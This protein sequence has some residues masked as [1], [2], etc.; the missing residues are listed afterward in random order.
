MLFGI[1]TGWSP[2]VKAEGTS[3]QSPTF[4]QDG[5]V[6]VY[7][8]TDQSQNQVYING[9]FV[10]WASFEPLTLEGTYNNNGI[11]Q[12]LFSYTLTTDQ[13]NQVGGVIQ[14]KFTPSADWNGAYTDP[15]NQSPKKDGNSTIYFLDI[16]SAT[17]QLELGQSIEVKAYRIL[18]DGSKQYMTDGINWQSDNDKVTVVNGVVTAATDATVNQNVA[19]SVTYLGVTAKKEFTI[20]DEVLKS[21]VMN[22]DGTVTFNAMYDGATLNLVGSMNG[23]NNQG[24]PMTKNE[25]GIFTVTTPLNPGTYEYKFFPVSGS[26]DN[27]FKDPLN[28]LEN[29]GNSVV[30]VP[31]IKIE[32]ADEIQLGDSITL[33]AKMVNQNGEITDINPIWSLKENREGITLQDGVLSVAAN[34]P[35]T[36]QDRIIVVAEKD[37]YHAEK[38]INILE[39]MYSYTIH[40][41][42]YDGKQNQWDMWIWLDG[43]EGNAYPF[44]D[45]INGF[46][47]A[48]YKFP[49]NKINVIVRP[50]NWSTQ[51]MTRTVEVK[52]GTSVEVWIIQ[53]VE[54][55]FYSK[56]EADIS[57][58]VKAALMDALDTIIVSTTH[59]VES[60]D[61]D[62]FV[63]SDITSN[64][65]IA[66]TATKL[67][68][69]K[70]KLTI[71]D[72]SQVDVR[73]LYQVK[74]NRFAPANVTVRKALDDPKFYYNGNDLGLTYSKE[75]S[76]FKVWAPTATKVSVAL[77]DNAGTYNEA[78]VVL[79]HTGSTEYLMN[80]AENGVW[81][82]TIDGDLVGKYYMYKVEL[83]DGT[84]NYAVDPYARAVSAN[85]QRTAI[86]DLESTIPN[87]WNPNDKPA[88]VNPTDAVIYELHVRDFSSN[89][90]SKMQYKGKF[91][92]FT[93]TGLKDDHGNSIGIDH[94][95]DLGITHVHLLPSYD[96]KTINELTVDDPTST[97]PKFNWGYDPQN[98]NVPEGS[99]STNPQNPTA[100]ITEFKEMVQALHDKGIRVIMDVV[101]NHTYSVEDGPFNKIVPGYFYRTNDDGKYT[102]GSGVGN[103]VASER[104]M[105]RKFIKDSVKYWAEE[106][107][108]DGF[109]FD[110]M[111]L[112]DV[113]T[114]TQLTK[115]LKEQVDPTILIYGE[116]WQ[117]GGSPLPAELQ[118]TKGQQKDKGFA[119]FNDNLRGAI[120]GGSDDASKGFATGQIGTEAGIVTGIKGAIDDFTNSPTE[121]INYVTAHD[122]LNLWDKIVKT[123]G[124]ED[125][126]GFLNIQDGVLIDGGSVEEAVANA[127]PYQYVGDDVLANETVKRSLLANGI[128][129]TSQGIPFIHAGDEI[130]RTKYG[131][132]NS[133][134]SPDAVNQIR[135]ENKDRFKPVFDY[136]QGLIALRKSH[137]A[138]R[139]S[140]KEAVA[141]NFEV[142]KS[143]GNIVVFKL[144]NHAN[145]DPWE[146][147]VVIYNANSSQA[148]IN[149]P[150]DSTQWNVVVND[151]QAG[152][153]VIDT[154]EGNQVTVPGLSMMVLYDE[155]NDYTPVISKIEVSP[156]VMGL[157]IG[158]TKTIQGIVKDQYNN[159][160]LNETISW[161]S[162]NE[163]VATVT[164]TGRVTA[165]GE[166]QAIITASVGDISAT[167][168][169]NVGTL[170]PTTIQLTGKNYVFEGQSTQLTADVKDQFQQPMSTA[171]VSWQSSD[172]SIATVD[173][174]GKVTG[175]KTGTVTIT[176]QAGDVTASKQIEVKAYVQRTIQL[177]YI[178]DDQDYTDWNLWVWGTGVQD[179][180][181]DIDQVV[182]GAALFTIE[183]GP[184]T[185][186]V[187]FIV[188]KGTDWNTAKQDIPDDRY[189][190][191]DIDESLTK[192]TVTSMVKEIYTVPAVK[193]PVLENGNLTFYYR[194]PDLFKQNAMDSIKSVQVKVN[195]QTYDMTYMPKEERFVYTLQAISEG[196]YDYSFLVT[197]D[198]NTVEV[199]DPYNTQDGKSIIEYKLP[200]IQLDLSLTPNQITYQENTVLKVHPI[201]EEEVGIKEIYVDLT[202]LGGPSKA[203]VDLT[204]LEQTLSVKDDIPAGTKTLQV[205]LVDEFGNQHVQSINLEI[206]PRQYVGNPL[207]FDWDEA[208]IY[209]ILT[210]RF[211]NGDPSNDDPNGE[212]YDKSHPETYHGGDLKGITDKLDYLQSL[213]INTIWISPI[214]DNID[215]NLRY[216]KE[217]PQYG[218]HG[219]WAKDFTQVDEHFGDLETL[220]ELIDKA[221]D[222]GIKIMVDVVLNHAGY[223][224]KASDTGEGI[225]NFPTD[226]DRAR[227]A[228]MFRD[229]GTDTIK[230]ELA[231]LPDFKT[232]D[233]AVRAKIIEWQT[234]W[235][236]KART[237]RGDTIDYFRVDTVK[238]VEDTTW[239][240][241]KNA[242]TKIKP[243][244]KL[245]GENFGANIDNTGGYLNS[246]QMDS[247]LD[248]AFKYSAQNF[249]NGQIDDV[250]NYLEYRNSL[251]NNTATLGQFLSS[252]DEDGFLS[253]YVNGDKGK[254]K[255]AAALQIT[256]KGQPVIYYGEELGRSGK[257]AGN[258]DQGEFS[259][260]RG[261]M[262]WDQL[263]A[264][265]DLY[266]HYKKLLN[267]RK[268][269]SKVLS[270]GTRTKLAGGNAEG[271]LV[272][273]RTYQQQSVVVA[274]NTAQEEKEITFAV[275]FVSGAK[276][277]DHY[278]GKSYTVNSLGQLTIQL[279]GKDQGGTAI[280]ALYESPQANDHNDNKTK[281]SA[282]PDQQV[283]NE[284][285]LKQGK[286]GKVS[287]E[288]AKGKKEVLLPA[289]AAEIIKDKKVEISTEG[290]VAEIPTAVFKQLQDIVSADKLKDA[291]IS[292]KVN[293]VNNSEAIQL[294]NQSQDEKKL[295]LQ[296][297]SEI[298]DFNLAVVD[299]DGN[300]TKL[301]K[302]DQPITLTFGI[303]TNANVDLLGVYYLGENGQ[304]QYVG[305]T[306]LNGKITAEVQHF[307]QYA[308]LEYDKDFIDVANN[309]WA[310]DAIRK[311]A[312][313]HIVTGINDTQFAPTKA[314]TR[315]EFAAL[316]VRTLGLEA[317]GKSA[318]KDVSSDSW[319][320]SSVQA[321]FEAG[322]IQGQ[323]K[324]TFAPQEAISREEM[325]VMVMRA[326]DYLTQQQSQATDEL[327]F[328]DQD[329]ISQWALPAI[330]RASQLGLI[331]GK[332]DYF[333]PSGIA[334]R[335]ESAQ[336]IYNLLSKQK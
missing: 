73:H 322:I 273:K 141:N 128:V 49:A 207:D 243:D 165:V 160:M 85:G 313:K 277:K 17:S 144:K 202:P 76:S 192:V 41:Y 214:V 13:I 48:T 153:E 251:L 228:G 169:V 75:K 1:F 225:P 95:A 193:G 191:T 143:D 303:K 74:S 120:K 250:E 157:E 212:H 88:M 121:T 271:Y 25:K 148:V 57:A 104:P 231:G 33:K 77:Y 83:A 145:N 82:T 240:A 31:G 284:E 261:D 306:Y 320:V 302:F 314:I 283:V 203:N 142:V 221:H 47:T 319:Y 185:T 119:V 51:E 195:D 307:S 98:Y 152:N 66:V 333:D 181:I 5:T 299:P 131:D 70:V 170:V 190:T 296:V 151:K 59:T 201:T 53:D 323:T 173:A 252:H 206:K 334:T 286:D 278:N 71:N 238:H 123:Q 245:I 239:K 36:G 150:Q 222:Q 178:R 81:S 133:Y 179:G 210:D 118:T 315:A 64:Q 227:F 280:L 110:L 108:V 172:S 281:E 289:N 189:M 282:N 35:L 156:T 10:N 167:V 3:I 94:L 230:G 266:E 147:I 102:N 223:G 58:R 126:L 209:F 132:H 262:P 316:L 318:F 236:E 241:F 229:G 208:R 279:L 310:K 32:S 270:K 234:S 84:I 188:R 134:K 265:L 312:A 137:P 43:K 15:F 136:Y 184:E 61:L 68:D 180:Q 34:Y 197:K 105:V 287:I 263:N 30:H 268:D 56:E 12:N 317:S 224:L 336:L 97:N 293:K 176:A 100:R 257:N 50:G 116:P 78:G 26:W 256:A 324:T 112:I 20:V 219:Y 292:F 117:A 63:L 29:S 248:F 101:Y 301:E 139:M 294:L 111:G 332:G 300:V 138:F 4:N 291:Q 259:Q 89:D 16:E 21:P 309:H 96:F 325:A 276:V 14:Y 171:M 9:N 22:Q 329:Q 198:G 92:A 216:G 149:L 305:G 155:V 24:I 267:I 200:D 2:N 87:H 62:S 99:Y 67:T 218:Y 177:K 90:N 18:A 40:Y 93:E 220:K 106:Y 69:T 235:L 285:S 272:F 72:P 130:L 163:Q 182:D 174:N 253:E 264:E 11:T 186:N 297:A 39:K 79:D 327:R 275:P 260:N 330:K 127:D 154:I 86:V 122:N 107:N 249:V 37:G 135:W 164:S 6:T 255:V 247:L 109:R 159:P 42:R 168:T 129:L 226:E 246:G 211:F 308:V 91:K 161:S 328:V 158:A 254:L 242:L 103:E 23:W 166:G 215:W 175:I 233:P 232:E 288:I 298:V 8:L 269:Y 7:A 335:A 44:H 124:L 60:S 55:V 199:T 321:A 162:S 38:T 258:M 326:Y 244:F 115:E 52:E 146:N 125:E 46:A 237:D 113:D 140:T 65:D 295:N 187:G 183:I 45:S 290:I 80:R 311:L 304:I 196:T 274:L 217:G 54:Q 28:L 204:L 114:V 194:D 331:K 213:G 205:I 19:I 27:G